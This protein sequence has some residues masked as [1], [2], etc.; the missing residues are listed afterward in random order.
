[1]DKP[2]PYPIPLYVTD[3]V[4]IYVPTGA[5][6]TNALQDFFFGTVPPGE[7]RQTYIIEKP[8]SKVVIDVDT[9]EIVK[10][11]VA[12]EDEEEFRRLILEPLEEAGY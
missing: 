4:V 5:T 10:W 9:L 12:P 8:P 3:D 2:V 1:M 6:L 11:D 7:H